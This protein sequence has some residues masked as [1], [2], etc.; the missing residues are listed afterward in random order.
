[1]RNE[2]RILKKAVRQAPDLTVEN[3]GDLLV[4]TFDQSPN[5]VLAMLV[6]LMELDEQRTQ[7]LGDAATLV[8]TLG[9][10][11]EEARGT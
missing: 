10:V 4:A 5:E 1:M 3:L 6:H 7:M 2:I 11:I 9:R 8:T